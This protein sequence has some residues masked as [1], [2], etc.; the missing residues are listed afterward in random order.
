MK[1]GK[2]GFGIITTLLTEEHG[3]HEY[4]SG[5]LFPVIYSQIIQKL[6]IILTPII[7]T[8]PLLP[9]IHILSKL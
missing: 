4:L 9:V 6:V 3:R 8:P 2:M 1:D 7:L 5:P